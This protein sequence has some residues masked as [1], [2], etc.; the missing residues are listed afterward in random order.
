[1]RGA[2]AEKRNGAKTPVSTT[3]CANQR[4]I[5]ALCKCGCCSIVERT[6]ERFAHPQGVLSECGIQSDDDNLIFRE[7]LPESGSG[8]HT[9]ESSCDIQDF[10]DEDDRRDKLNLVLGMAI[11]KRTSLDRTV[12]IAKPLHTHGSIQHDDGNSHDSSP[13]TS[14]EPR[15]SRKISSI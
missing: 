3:V 11:E 14:S 2:L 5:E 15:S 9:V 6:A 8:I 7:A 10:M 13:S 4:R 1:V 12:L